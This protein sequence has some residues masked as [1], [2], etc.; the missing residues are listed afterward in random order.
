MASGLRKLPPAW[1]TRVHE[2]GENVIFRS[3]DINAHVKRL[4]DRQKR[5]AVSRAI[6]WGTR[7]LTLQSRLTAALGGTD[8]VQTDA[9]RPDALGTLYQPLRWKV[10]DGLHL[11][12]RDYGVSGTQ[13]LQVVCLPGLTRNSR[14]FEPVAAHLVPLGF[15][16]VTIDSRGRGESDRDPNPANYT[17]MREL[18]DA[19]AL[20]DG[21]GLTKVAAIGTSRGGML[22]MLGALARPDLFARSILNDIGPR[23]EL[24]GLLKIKG[25]V[26]RAFGEMTWDQAV[27]ALSVSQG[28]N[29]PRLDDD[30]WHRFARRIWRDEGGRPVNDYDPALALG[31][32]SLTA[33]T[34]MPEAWD[35]LAALAKNPVLVIR[36]GLSDILSNATVEDMQR[37]HPTIERWDVPY[38]AHAPLLEDAPTLDRITRF[39]LA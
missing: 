25:Y 31:M 11:M 4:L 27:F 29:F 2:G 38:E 20:L 14:D 1:Q 16:V 10:T 19:L 34:Q 12:G 9:A 35:A 22:M 7:A 5:L 24:D 18:I 21:L 15:R 37:R 33:D 13:T 32:A 3:I 6:N 30:G 8:I 39:L 23:I 36:G 26:G 28:K 17:P